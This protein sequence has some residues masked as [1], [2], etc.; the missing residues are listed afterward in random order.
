MKG[1][2]IM[3]TKGLLWDYR[4]GILHSDGVTWY[5]SCCQHAASWTT[6]IIQEYFSFRRCNKRSCESHA[7]VPDL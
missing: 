7:L 1:H 5:I 3:F 4:R 2:D 6:R